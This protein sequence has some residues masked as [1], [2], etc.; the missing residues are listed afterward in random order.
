M[1]CSHEIIQL[2]MNII[3]FSFLNAQASREVTSV[4]VYVC[5]CVCPF[6][7]GYTVKARD[8]KSFAK[9]SSGDQLKTVFSNF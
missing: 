4:C 6:D 9:D 7:Y 1:K 3:F 5:V 8:L 2:G